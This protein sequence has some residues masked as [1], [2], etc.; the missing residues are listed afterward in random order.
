VYAW[1][2][3]G[4]ITLA[5]V[6]MDYV[7][8]ED[9]AM[10]RPR[11]AEIECWFKGQC[12]IHPRMCS[13][14]LSPLR[15]LRFDNQIVEHELESWSEMFCGWKQ[16]MRL[17]LSISRYLGNTLILLRAC[18]RSAS[19]KCRPIRLHGWLHLQCSK[20]YSDF[21]EARHSEKKQYQSRK[22]QRQSKVCSAS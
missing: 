6:L 17:E 16:A 14:I 2:G 19:H 8:P 20:G 7:L 12:S 1:G 5:T 10:I 18:G 22:C 4:L 9:S 11:M 15:P 13:N 3:A 21:A